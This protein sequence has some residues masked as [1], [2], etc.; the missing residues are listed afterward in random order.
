MV[1]SCTHIY[2]IYKLLLNISHRMSRN[3]KKIL[4]HNLGNAVLWCCNSTCIH[5]VLWCWTFCANA[6]VLIEFLVPVCNYYIFPSPRALLWQE[7]NAAH[8]CHPG[9]FSNMTLAVASTDVPCTVYRMEAP[10]SCLLYG[11]TM[12]C[13]VNSSN[14]RERKFNCVKKTHRHCC[15]DIYIRLIIHQSDNSLKTP[16]SES[17]YKRNRE[18]MNKCKCNTVTHLSC[19]NMGSKTLKNAFYKKVCVF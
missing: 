8:Q 9:V 13:F 3:T 19:N 16:S 2:F 11:N 5:T 15:R 14:S 18:K 7:S 1:I 17:G 12:F 10:A 6:C 4:L